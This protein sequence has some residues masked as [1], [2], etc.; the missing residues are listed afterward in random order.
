M[1]K[2]LE[3]EAESLEKLNCNLV[4]ETART[5]EFIIHGSASSVFRFQITLLTYANSVNFLLTEL[6]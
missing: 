2:Y 4:S 6:Q 5:T 3:K 1:A